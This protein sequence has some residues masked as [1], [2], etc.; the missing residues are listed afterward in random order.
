MMRGWAKQG[1]RVE[2]LVV[3]GK[4]YRH[5]A[6][7]AEAVERERKREGDHIL[8]HQRGIQAPEGGPRSDYWGRVEEVKGQ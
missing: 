4:E 6:Q 5:K 3:M 1:G 2:K 8:R 7:K